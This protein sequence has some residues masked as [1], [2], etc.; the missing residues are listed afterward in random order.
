M[1]PPE[2]MLVTFEASSFTPLTAD[3]T[4]LEAVFTTS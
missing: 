2:I 1:L 4:V 3:S